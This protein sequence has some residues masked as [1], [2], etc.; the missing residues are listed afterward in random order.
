[1][2]NW[3]IKCLV[4]VFTVLTLFSLF[5]TADEHDHVVNRFTKFMLKHEQLVTYII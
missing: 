5:T 2:H 1:M 4:T 3:R